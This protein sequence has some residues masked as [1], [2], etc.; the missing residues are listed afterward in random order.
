MA[1]SNEESAV[2]R[3]VEMFRNGILTKDAAALEATTAPELSYSH[4]KGQ[5]EDRSTFIANATG[6][7]IQP[8]KLEYSDI[9]IRIVDNVAIVRLH[10]QSKSLLTK[11]NAHIETSVYLTMTW[12]NRD[13]HWL[14]LCR[15]ATLVSQTTTPV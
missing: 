4:S 9:T 1:G 13:D 14:L 12:L 6:P 11:I 5:I 8:I 2:A 3:A 15:A 10:M 7:N